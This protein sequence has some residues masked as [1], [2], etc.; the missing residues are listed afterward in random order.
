MC[1]CVRFFLNQYIQCC[2]PIHFHYIHILHLSFLPHKSCYCIIWV[3]L[4]ELMV[5][6]VLFYCPWH[7][8]L[9][10]LFPIFLMSFETEYII[11]LRSPFS[12][13]EWITNSGL[14]CLNVVNW[15]RT[16]NVYELLVRGYYEIQII[17]FL[18]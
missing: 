16:C 10:I 18:K 14:C 11:S 9:Y 13:L 3:L 17:Y 2:K 7:S 1:V 4:L 12:V 8:V 6:F 5:L 15:N